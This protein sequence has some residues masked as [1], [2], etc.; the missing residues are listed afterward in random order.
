MP[1]TAPAQPT[2]AT[3]RA[4][5]PGSINELDP[6]KAADYV[7]GL[8]LDQIFETPYAT[9]AGQ[10]SVTPLLF[11]ALRAEDTVGLHYSAAVRGGISFSDGTPLTA[12]IAA[13]SLHGASAL[14]GKATIDVRDDR[15]WFTLTS[16]N[17]RFALTLTHS[18][19]AIVHA[20]GM[21]LF[22]TGP[23]MFDRRPNLRLLQSVDSLRLVRNP[24]Y[25][26]KTKIDE[27]EFRVLRPD[28]D[29]TPRSLIEALRDGTIDLT[30]AL[31]A[32][33]VSTWNLSG[34]VPITQPSNSTALLF[35]NSEHVLF[36][37]A[38]ARKGIA[39]GIDLLEIASQSYSRNP[40]A[41]IATSTLPPA[42]TRN[43][44]G[45]RRAA[46]DA[47]R[48]IEESGLRGSRLT[49]LVPWAPRP[50]LPKP[51]TAARLIQRQL[52]NAGITVTL[53]E[54]KTSDDYFGQLSAGRFHLAL[55]GWIADT[56]DPADFFEALLASHSIGSALF[57]N[58]SRWHDAHTDELL[59][60][61]R[62]DPSDANRRELEQ[63]IVDE[64][65]FLPL[66]YG[67]SSAVHAR[68]VRD[69]VL[70]PTGSVFLGELRIA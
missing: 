58:Y 54:P 51:L 42:M 62:I 3:I 25:H 18:S 49:L 37:N 12:E 10:T 4:G 2:T 63:L 24:H 70:T 55:G 67:Q 64:A 13:R 39:A 68:R 9:L 8:I 45:F 52:G 69:V 59:V 35:I 53:I 66:I 65:P 32:S 48:L 5:V 29:G 44:G 6:R 20:T 21:Q 40:A 34:V 46:S 16:A 36:R 1:E 56:P 41:F 30:T 27:I 47:S 22:G 57:S 61:F 23:F 19:C 15:V 60:R 11:E 28:A 33:D 38:A 43:G 31:S 17:P 50:Y 14:T 26:R 7:S